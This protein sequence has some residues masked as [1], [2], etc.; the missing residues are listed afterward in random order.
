MRPIMRRELDLPRHGGAPG[1]AR[2]ALS[3]W[4]G[5]CLDDEALDT[6]KLVVSELVTN[7][8]RHGAGRI[9]LA[10]GL[11][12]DH[13]LIEVADEGTG[14]ASSTRDIPF[15]KTGGRGLEIVAAASSRWGFSDGTTHVWAEIEREPRPSLSAAGNGLNAKAPA[16][17]D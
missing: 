6:G 11:D 4:F 1:V 3:Q 15:H 9:R 17:L 5:E 12:D 10:A 7:A 2:H 13:L 14:F 8:V 16:R